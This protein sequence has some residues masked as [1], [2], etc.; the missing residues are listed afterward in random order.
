L[1]GRIRRQSEADSSQG[2]S[3]LAYF[4]EVF[5]GVEHLKGCWTMLQNESVL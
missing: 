4:F 2:K 1:Y 5:S 3:K